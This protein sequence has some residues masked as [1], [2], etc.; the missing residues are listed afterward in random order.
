MISIYS[1]LSKYLVYFLVLLPTYSLSA[2]REVVSANDLKQK[3]EENVLAQWQQLGQ[4]SDSRSNVIITG[5]PDSYRSHKCPEQLV[6]DAGKQL[7]LGRNSIKVSCATTSS[8]SLM[9]TAEIEVWREVVVIRDHLSRGERIKSSSLTLQE[10]NIS[11]LQRGYFTDLKDVTNQ[12]SKRS[13]RA[14]VA[15]DPS[16]IDL[17]IIIRRGQEITLRVVKPG[18]SVNMKG[19]SL[20]KGRKGDVIKVKNSRTEKV[21]FGTVISADLISVN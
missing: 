19:I 8:W 6:V 10:R 21:L 3:V 18:F 5:L 16:M 12:V 20:S 9:L 15:I 1:C 7:T 17:P 4:R 14:G 13:L 11:S 2:A